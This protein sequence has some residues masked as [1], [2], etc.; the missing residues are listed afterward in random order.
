MVTRY[1]LRSQND[2][3]VTVEGRLERAGD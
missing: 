1:Q 3:I 2:Q